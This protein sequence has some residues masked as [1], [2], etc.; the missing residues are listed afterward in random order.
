MLIFLGLKKVLPPHCAKFVISF[1]QL[2]RLRGGFFSLC[3]SDKNNDTAVITEETAGPRVWFRLS[4]YNI[5]MGLLGSRPR[6]PAPP[7]SPAGTLQR[8]AGA[9]SRG[10]EAPEP[11]NWT[12]SQLI[13]LINDEKMA[14]RYTLSST[15]TVDRETECPICFNDFEFLNVVCCCQ[16]LICTNCYIKLRKPLDFHCL[17]PFCDKKGFLVTFESKKQREEKQGEGGGTTAAATSTPYRSRTAMPDHIPLS[18]KADRRE[19]EREITISRSFDVH[20]SARYLGSGERGRSNSERMTP[21]RYRGG[22]GSNDRPR[23]P[24]NQQDAL[25]ELTRLLGDSGEVDR[26]EEIMLM[27]AMRASMQDVSTGLPPPPTMTS[28]TPPAARPASPTASSSDSS[29]SVPSVPPPAPA[30]VPA[31]AP[32]PVPVLAPPLAH[33]HFEQERGSLGGLSMS[34]RGIGD[35]DLSEEEQLQIAI[36]LSMRRPSSPPER[37]PPV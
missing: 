3:P 2:P 28:S 35:I 17:C 34:D 16:H 20:D 30:R 25:R 26:L 4:A 18:S 37:D 21:G 8:Q 10:K 22:R 11:V 15:I 12:E 32:V 36:D 5:S 31:P 6:A 27:A 14:P 23:A 33:T 24:A 7:V 1:A 13:R 9:G 29:S 19:L